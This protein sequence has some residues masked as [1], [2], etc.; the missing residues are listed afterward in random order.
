VLASHD[1]NDNGKPD[2]IRQNINNGAMSVWL[3][4]GLIFISVGFPSAG[5]SHWTIQD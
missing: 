2:V 5:S 1:L 3:M 4:N